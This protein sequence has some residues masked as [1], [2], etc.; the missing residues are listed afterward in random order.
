MTT[1]KVTVILAGSAAG[2]V[3]SFEEA[4]VAAD[5]SSKE[6]S[7]AF[8]VSGEKVGNVFTKLGKATAG[9]PILGSTFTK[10]GESVEGADTKS[11][12]FFQTLSNVGKIATVAVAAGIVAV[13]A[14]SVKLAEKYQ[15]ATA[16][17]QGSA[18]ISAGAAK[19]I[20]DAFL[21]TGFKTVFSAQQ[22]MQAYSGVAA[23]LGTIQGKALDAAQ[24]SQFMA[25]AGDLAEGSNTDL[26][27][28]TA[29]LAATMQ[30]FHIATSGAAARIR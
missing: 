29:A 28:T 21:G 2:L 4:S 3:K 9:I 10:M 5:A 15:T 19:Q 18:N 11:G 12:K 22:Q 25:A 27:T 8:A 30:A 14:E 16:T 20:G 17:L 13:G 6:M 24:A 1:K 23:Q 7:A 26:N